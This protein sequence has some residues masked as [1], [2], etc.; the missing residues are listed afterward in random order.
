MEMGEGTKKGIKVETETP[1]ATLEI[2]SSVLK[3]ITVNMSYLFRSTLEFVIPK[4][5]INKSMID[6]AQYSTLDDC[7]IPHDLLKLIEKENVPI[8]K[9]IEETNKDE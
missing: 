2:S 7:D 8:C 6:F 5:V 9:I 4:D 1:K 3:S